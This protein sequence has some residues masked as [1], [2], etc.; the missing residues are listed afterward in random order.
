MKKIP[1]N[2]T[3]VFEGVIFDVYH[4]QQEMFDGSL[5]TFEAV[6]RKDS[7]S[8]IAVT[9][10]NLILVNEEQQPGKD[11]FISFPGGRIDENEAPLEAAKRELLEETGYVSDNW[12]QWL[13]TDPFDYKKIEWNVYSYIARGC[14]KIAE[15]SL[16]GGEKIATKLLTFDEFLE[17]RNNPRGRN[18][19]LTEALEKASHN[20]E[21]KEKLKT[22]LGITT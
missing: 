8:I 13:I 19:D 18:K 3:R 11:T 7:V 1:D 21:E 15:Q 2:A 16:D 14:K 4:W 20:E 10:D 22:L 12:E 6:K 17:L 5:A 9:D